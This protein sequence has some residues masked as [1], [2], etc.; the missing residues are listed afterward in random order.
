MVVTQNIVSSQFNS[1]LLDFTQGWL[2]VFGVGV[3]G[4]TVLGRKAVG[5]PGEPRPPHRPAHEAE[6]KSCET[7]RRA[8][9][10]AAA[11]PHPGGG[12]AA[13]RRRAVRDAADPQHPPRLAAGAD[14]RAGVRGHRRH[15]RR[16]SATSTASSPCRRRAARWRASR[17]RYACSSAMTSRSRPRAATARPFCLMAG[18]RHVGPIDGGRRGALRRALLRRSVPMAGAC[19]GSRR[20]CVSRMRSASRG[21]RRGV[22]GRRRAAPSVPREPL[23]GD[24]RGAEYSA[25]S[26]GRAKA[27]ARSPP[28]LPNAA[29]RSSR[30]AA[31]RRRARLSRRDLGRRRRGDAPRR[32]G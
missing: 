31:R 20:C 12:A 10:P 25:T 29:S 22:P 14:R 21:C 23:R 1:H 7:V 24:P 30:P 16:Q 5:A 18:R 32:R 15:A 27:G 19:I 26:D 4:G 9:R 11:S 8:A 6:M 3:F 2:Y 28:R 17:S 13:A